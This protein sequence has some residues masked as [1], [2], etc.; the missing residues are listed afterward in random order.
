[1]CSLWKY[2]KGS[3]KNPC[4]MLISCAYRE[5]GPDFLNI[6]RGVPIEFSIASTKLLDLFQ[7]DGCTPDA[8]VIFLASIWSSVLSLELDVCYL[9]CSLCDF[10]K[11]VTYL[12]T[13]CRLFYHLLE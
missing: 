7:R 10:L 2:S 6:A 9:L 11:S 12:T 4:K 5:V 8:K 1:M 13:V 3:E